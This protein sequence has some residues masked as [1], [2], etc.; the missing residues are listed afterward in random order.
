M[1]VDERGDG[2]M[3]VTG[4]DSTSKKSGRIR[5]SSRDLRFLLSY[6]RPYRG[7]FAIALIALLFS[8]FAGLAF[9]GLTG[10]LIDAVQHPGDS[11]FAS[12]DNLALFFLAI[13]LIQSGFSYVRTYYMQEVSERSLA[14]MRA[15]LYSH[16]LGL[17][18]DFFHRHRVGDLTSRLT[19][20]I[21]TIQTT[22]TT[23]LSELI[24]QSILLIG[25]I[26]L[27]VYTSS[28]LTLV[29][30]GALPVVVALAVWFG[31]IIRKASRRVQDLYAELNTKAEETF[32]GISIVKAFT[33]E[34]R[35]R[36]SF[37][38]K[39][40][41]IIQVSL[42]VARARAAF[43]AFVVFILFGGVV[44][45]VWYGGRLVQSGELTIGELTSFVLYAAF[46]GGAMGSFADLY[47]SLQRA[48]GA[49]EKI[50]EIL[51]EDPEPTAEIDKESVARSSSLD[52]RLE[53]VSFSY[54]TRPD[55]GVLHSISLDI[56]SGGSLALVGPSGSGKST[57]ANLLLRF[58]DPVSGAIISDGQDVR[59]VPVKTWRSR[60]AVVPQEVLLFGGTIEANL[61]YGNPEASREEIL[62][63]ARQANALE[64][65]SRFPEGM[66]TLVGER[67]VQL[68]GGEKQRVAIA[69]AILRDPDLLILDEATSALDSASERLVQGALE[70]LMDGRTSI[71]IA[72]RLST[73]R[74]ADQIAVL[75]HGRVVEQGT[76]DELLA[77]DGLFRT[78][79]MIQAGATDIL[80]DRLDL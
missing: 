64:F 13:L 42:G 8:S 80:D 34:G 11:L 76:Y 69:R 24:R 53:D 27:V 74:K 68:S 32:Q 41:S 43:I 17:P 65:I 52:L 49:A 29:I 48:L 20:D 18:I 60:V 30:L 55:V 37:G 47:G 25:G 9:P 44:G 5:L 7:K 75:R 23:T 31:R 45:V 1:R 33:A 70:R 36:K 38:D 28:R 4:S 63:A 57:I 56:P 61:S 66:D 21:T 72:H 40:G 58:Y 26:T 6:I 35:E 14:D 54:P 15:D 19:S 62:G 50:R 73:I 10:A 79:L 51:D 71:V 22:L 16:V 78:M 59:E 3:V 67:G 77:S 39:L 2:E 12:L 46:V